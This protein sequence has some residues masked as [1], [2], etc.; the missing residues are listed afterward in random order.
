M[1]LIHQDRGKSRERAER[2]SAVEQTDKMRKG[3]QIKPNSKALVRQR[4]KPTERQP[5]VGEV[6]ANFSG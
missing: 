1:K 4:T 6:S 5:F 2:E 3:L